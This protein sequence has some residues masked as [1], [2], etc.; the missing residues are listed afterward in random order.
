MAAPDLDDD[1]ESEGFADAGGE[2]GSDDFS[3]PG[4]FADSDGLADA[5]DRPA[6]A[7]CP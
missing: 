5:L 2:A 1:A 4:N 6:A 3:D 7:F